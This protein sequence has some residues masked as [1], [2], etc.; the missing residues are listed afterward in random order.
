MMLIQ[1]S[2]YDWLFNTQTRVLLAD[3][4]IKEKATL[5]MSLT[6]SRQGLKQNMKILKMCKRS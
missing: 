6:Y 3:L 4:E 2:V 5:C 1:H